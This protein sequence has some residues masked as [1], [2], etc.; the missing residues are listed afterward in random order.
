MAFE[1]KQNLERSEVQEAWAAESAAAGSGA[2]A[3]PPVPKADEDRDSGDVLNEIEGQSWGED[4]NDVAAQDGQ[5]EAAAEEQQDEEALETPAETEET[6][7]AGEQAEIERPQ[8]RGAQQRIQQLANERR[9]FMEISKR[10]AETISKLE[11]ALAR[12]AEIEAKRF[13]REEESIRLAR[14]SQRIRDY[15]QELIARGEDP[16]NPVH[17]NNL[18]LAQT[19]GSMQQELK[20]LQA[21]RQQA[22]QR[23]A[24]QRYVGALRTGL[25]ATLA[26]Y[27]VSATEREGLL[28]QAYAIAQAYQVQDPHQAVQAALEPV[29]ARLPKKNK[30]TT[31]KPGSKSTKVDAMTSMRGQGGK[32]GNT[33]GGKEPKKTP[34]QIE[35]EM[36]AGGW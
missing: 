36:G 12:S 27:D 22:E 7:E 25:D 23:E 11:A 6:E 3:K 1:T 16:A 5:V 33:P 35:R 21:E 32:K 28:R 2:R 19:L 9:E 20:K 29:I 10:Q 24:V 8:T 31:A 18:Q 34:E 14:E 17:Q 13:E 15:E 30:T 4:Q 26:G